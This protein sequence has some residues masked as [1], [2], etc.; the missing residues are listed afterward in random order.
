MSAERDR[1]RKRLL[2]LASADDAVTAAANTGSYVSGCGDEWSD[3]DLAFGIRG[4]L[5]PALDR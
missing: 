4:E 2:E 3:I 1:A 5:A